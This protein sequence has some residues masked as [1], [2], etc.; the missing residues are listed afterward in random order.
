VA[1]GF[2]YGNPNPSVVQA[3][4]DWMSEDRFDITAAADQ[5]WRRA[6]RNESAHRVADDAEPWL[7]DRFVFGALQEGG[8][9]PP[10]R[11]LDLVGT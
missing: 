11:L 2:D 10:R 8:A 6:G 7:K 9:K 5:A 3:S 1:F 4:A